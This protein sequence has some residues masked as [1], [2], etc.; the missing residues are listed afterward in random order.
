MFDMA[1]TAF[2]TSMC[3]SAMRV[4]DTGQNCR[5]QQS[6]HPSRI[7]LE[8]GQAA[9]RSSRGWAAT[10][11]FPSPLVE[12]DVRISRIQLSDWTSS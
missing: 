9:A 10:L 7:L 11:G 12:P 8:C 3:T 2:G 6:A 5:Q 1:E 4:R